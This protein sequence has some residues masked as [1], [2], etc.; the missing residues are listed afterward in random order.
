MWRAWTYQ[1]RYRP[2]WRFR[3]GGPDRAMLCVHAVTQDSLQPQHER[4]TIHMWD[5]PAVCHD[6]QR[7]FCRWVFERLLDVERHEAA[8]WFGVG[9]LRPYWPAH[10]DGDPYE[11]R[12]RWPE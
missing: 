10:G 8:E 11:H 9:E 3:P 6:D 2:G 7:A 4:R 5:V 1:L 12:E